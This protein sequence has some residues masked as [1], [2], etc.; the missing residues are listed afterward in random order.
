MQLS[1]SVPWLRLDMG[2]VARRCSSFQVLHG[3]MVLIERC[4][5]VDHL[6]GCGVYTHLVPRLASNLVAYLHMRVYGVS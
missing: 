6:S 1:L 3:S 4:K 5:V 2:S